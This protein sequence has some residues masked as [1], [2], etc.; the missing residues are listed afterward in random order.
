MQPLEFKKQSTAFSFKT[1]LTAAIDFTFFSARRYIYKSTASIFL[2]INSRIIATRYEGVSLNNN[3]ADK[4]GF[5]YNLIAD[6]SKELIEAFGVWGKKKFR[7]E[8]YFGVI[9]TTFI[10]NEEGLIERIIEKVNTKE[11]SSQILAD[12]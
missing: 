3:F 11:H 12:D 2:S 1:L 4:F 6:D 10:I 9:R 7:G 5:N 8:E